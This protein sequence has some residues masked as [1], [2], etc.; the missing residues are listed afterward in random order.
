MIGGAWRSPRRHQPA[1]P[2]SS[3]AVMPRSARCAAPSR[4]PRPAGS[5]SRARQRHA[6]DVALLRASPDAGAVDARAVGAAALAVLHA[7]AG[8]TPLLLAVDDLQWL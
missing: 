5:S 2:W 1:G 3:S 8:E 7:A 4:R 6:L